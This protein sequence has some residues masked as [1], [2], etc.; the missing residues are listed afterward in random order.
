[1]TIHPVGSLLLSLQKSQ[2]L[3][4]DAPRK[5]KQ[6]AMHFQKCNQKSIEESLNQNLG[7]KLQKRGLRR[8]RE[9]GLKV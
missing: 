7:A 9:R 5:G 6:K 1:M 4:S 8:L 3:S 2:E